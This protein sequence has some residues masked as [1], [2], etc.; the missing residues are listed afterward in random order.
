M[1]TTA[2]DVAIEQ[3]I[4]QIQNKEIF[5]G[6]RLFETD[7]EKSLD[8][9]RT[10]IR[11]ALDQLV[12]DGILE[13]KQ[14]QRGY[15]FP[16]LSLADLFE[17]YTFRERLEVTSVNLA[18]LKWSD[19]KE[20]RM[21]EALKWESES[22]NTQIADTYKDISN[23]YHVTLASASDNEYLVRALKQ[24]YLRIC[25]Y[26]LFYGISIYRVNRSQDQYKY[27]NDQMIIQHEDIVAS[28]AQG[29]SACATKKML[30]HLRNTAVVC[31]HVK[32]FPG[33]EEYEKLY[34]I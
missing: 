23:G 30:H 7:L 18:C 8:M 15:F 32:L 31:E 9:S 19:Q 24:V 1:K 16:K 13:K 22:S 6:A 33:W 2:Q 25:M 29:D 3:I 14:C 20:K 4:R 10:P 11:G 26:E 21:Y 34:P 28:I 27:L 17:A 5:P 12:A